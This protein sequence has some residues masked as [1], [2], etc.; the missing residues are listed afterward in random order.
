MEI[1]PLAD[2]I[3][4]KAITEETTSSGIVLPDT[5]KDKSQKGRVVAVG[6]GRLLEN[7]TRVPLEVRAQDV[8]LFEAGSG[9]KVKLGDEEYLLL[10]EADVLAV[11]SE[12]P[13]LV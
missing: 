1:R 12:S 3:V 2:K 11:L 6:S 9:V 4:V 5:A 10:R 7:G 8:V 13:A